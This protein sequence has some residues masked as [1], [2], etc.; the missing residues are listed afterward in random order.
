MFRGWLILSPTVFNRDIKTRRNHM[1]IKANVITTPTPYFPASSCAQETGMLL[2]KRTGRS[3]P[4]LGSD[5]HGLKGGQV[6]KSLLKVRGGW[7]IQRMSHWGQGELESCP[8]ATANQ[9]CDLGCAATLSF[10]LLLRKMGMK[11]CLLCQVVLST[12]K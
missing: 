3:G 7:V 12:P 1:K 6:G 4:C 9:L 10:C 8:N 5:R 2:L 11:G